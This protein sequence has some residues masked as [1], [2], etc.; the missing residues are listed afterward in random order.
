MIGGQ[1]L[2]VAS[3]ASTIR[4]RKYPYVWLDSTLIDTLALGAQQVFVYLCR[5]PDDPSFVLV[6]CDKGVVS[7]YDTLFERVA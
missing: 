1:L 4:V 5:D 2:R 7:A 3:T 6:M